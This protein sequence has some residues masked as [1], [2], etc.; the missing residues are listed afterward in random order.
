M[1]RLPIAIILIT[2][3]TLALLPA[4]IG[5]PQDP[6]ADWVASTLKNMTLDEKIGQM[7]MPQTE[8]AF[9]N[10]N[11]DYIQRQKARITSMHVGGFIVSRGTPT[12][13]AAFINELQRTAKIP[14]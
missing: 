1:K 8:G 2:T 5:A 6:R 14:L 3:L 11:S 9:A 10:F 4:L 13:T 12:D 7:I